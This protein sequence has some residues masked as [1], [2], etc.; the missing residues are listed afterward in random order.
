MA[1]AYRR[2]KGT[3]TVQMHMFIEPDVKDLIDR[4][5]EVSGLPQWAI[6]EAA[7]R[8]GRPDSSGLPA[9]WNLPRLGQEGLPLSA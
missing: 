9:S 8:A 4:Y 6:V 5:A 7:I 2:K 1:S 3:P